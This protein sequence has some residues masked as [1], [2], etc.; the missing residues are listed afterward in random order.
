MQSAKSDA[1]FAVNLERQLF[2]QRKSIQEE[3]LRYR[4][5]EQSLLQGRDAPSE[6]SAGK[7]GKR[8]DIKSPEFLQ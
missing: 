8:R 1:L 3:R 2:A 5:S 6:N 7:K 4:K